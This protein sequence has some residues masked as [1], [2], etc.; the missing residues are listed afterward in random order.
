M[1]N[2]DP[3]T[4]IEDNTWIASCPRCDAWRTLREAGGIR[5]GAVSHGKRVLGW[6]RTCH[7]FRM[8]R[9]QQARQIPP[10]QLARMT[11]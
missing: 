3:S 1:S 9:V 4:P 10:D 7:W 5:L 11:R 2:I 8:F 6:C